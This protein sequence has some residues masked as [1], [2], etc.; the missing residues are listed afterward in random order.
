MMRALETI[1]VTTFALFLVISIAQACERN[2]WVDEMVKRGDIA[3]TFK[4]N[5]DL[6]TVSCNGRKYTPLQCK[7]ANKYVFD[8]YKNKKTGS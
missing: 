3:L 5:G 7:N 6:S 8:Y 4:P 1:F 2:H